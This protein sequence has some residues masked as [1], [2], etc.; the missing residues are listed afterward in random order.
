MRA[1]ARGAIALAANALDRAATLTPTP[2][3]RSTRLL[4][5]AELTIEL[6]LPGLTIRLVRD[7]ESLGVASSDLGRA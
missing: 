5:T 2:E 7:A 6:G 3:I 1:E 4:R